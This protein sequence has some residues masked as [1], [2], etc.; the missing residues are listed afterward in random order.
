M[1]SKELIFARCFFDGTQL[2]SCAVFND[3]I[4]FEKTDVRVMLKI[5]MS[6]IN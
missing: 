5:L 4:A 3:K 1:R 6:H 2:V